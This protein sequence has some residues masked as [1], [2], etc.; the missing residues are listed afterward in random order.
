MGKIGSSSAFQRSKGQDAGTFQQR[1]LRN[2]EKRSRPSILGG[3]VATI[4]AFKKSY[5]R[6]VIHREIRNP[7]DKKS[8]HFKVAKSGI[9]TKCKAPIVGLAVLI[10]TYQDSVDRE[11]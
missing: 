4:R 1:K 7:V 11:S 8:K 5:E 9:P 2:R 6:K 3:R 10:S